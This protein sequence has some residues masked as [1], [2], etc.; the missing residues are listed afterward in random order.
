MPKGA[1]C[2]CPIDKINT[3]LS[4]YALPTV[5]SCKHSFELQLQLN[6][7]CLVYT[8]GT[9]MH[10]NVKY[11][12][13]RYINIISNVT[14]SCLRPKKFH[15]SDENT[16]RAACVRRRSIVSRNEI[17]TAVL[18]TTQAAHQPRCHP[19]SLHGF[20]QHPWLEC[21]ASVESVHSGQRVATTVLSVTVRLSPSLSSSL[22][23][24][25]S[26]CTHHGDSVPKVLLYHKKISVKRSSYTY[27]NSNDTD[28][29][30]VRH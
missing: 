22:S 14:Q 20:V 23:L 25:L 5:T 12:P 30:L 4:E 13:R 2:W 17:L 24:S 9:T 8:F 11:G 1:I 26:L 15:Q 29:L 27:D 19:A 18:L 3:F 21:S 7:H 6:W 16:R 10:Y 28:L